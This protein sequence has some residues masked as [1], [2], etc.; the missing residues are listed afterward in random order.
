MTAA[1]AAAS[2]VVAAHTAAAA[3]GGA[4]P[5]AQQGTIT[6][7]EFADGASITTQYQPNG[8]VFGGDTPF[9]TDDGA[10]PTSPV[11]SGT[12]LFFGTITGTFVQPDGTAR[13]VDSFSL[14]VGY[15]DTPGSTE[16][17]AYDSGGTV[18]DTVPVS[19]FGIVHVT[20]SVPGIASFAV[21]SV[22]QGNPDP[23]GFAIDNLS[24]AGY[25]FLTGPPSPGEQGSAP[26][27]SENQT[28]CAKQEPVNCA[29]G[30]FFTQSADFTI[31][32]RGAPLS[33]SR[34][35]ESPLA[36]SDGPFGFGWANSYSMT[37]TTDGSG[38]ATISQEDGSTVTFIPNGSGGFTAPT[39]VLATLV[40][41]QDGTYT[42]TRDSTQIQYTFSA[43]GQLTRETDRNGY[44][45]GLTY[46]NGQLTSV[47]DPAGRKFTFSYSGGHVASVTDP[48]GRVWTY[49]YDGSGNLT[50]ATDPAGRTWS[51]T[52]DSNHLMLTVT[53]P[54]GGVTANVYN[55]SGQVVSQTDP[56]GGTTT[57]SYAGDPASPGGGTTTMTDP[58]NEV[59][60]YNYA[61]LELA[62][63]TNAAATADATTTSY[64]YD[65]AT[66][67]VTS[68]T[69]P[70]GNVSTSTYDSNG[71][72]LTST[73]PLGNTAFY[74]YNSFNE[75]LTKTT[76]LGETTSYTY[77]SSGNLLTSTDPLG[78]VTTYAYGDSTHPGDVTSVTDPGGNVAT[79]TYDAN[80]DLAS[81]TRSPSS[82]VTDTTAY[83]YDADGERTCTASPNAT[84][85]G[86][87]CPAAGG[88]VAADTTATTYNADG[89][90]TSVTD[91][92][93]RVTSY[94]YDA[95][96]NRSKVTDPAG[97][98]TSYGYNGNNWRTKV[99]RADGTSL[100]STYDA[101]GN[102][103]SQ[104]NGAGQATSYTYN[105][106][107]QVTSAT[108]PLGHKTTY[109]YDA[110]GNRISLTDPSGKVTSYSYDGDNRLTAISYSDG[111]TPGVS[112]FYDGDG[113]RSAM[114]DGTGTTSYTYDADGHLTS[115]QNGAGAAV[116][117]GYGPTGQVTSLTY[118]NGNTVSR[119]YNGAGEL[120]AISDWL[121][122]TTKF[123]YDHS[124]N[125]TSEAYPNG[126]TAAIGYDQANQPMS[127][128]DK[129]TSATVASFAY[130]RDSLG[131]VTSTTQGGSLSGSQNYSYTHL[132]QLA[133]DSTGSYSYDAA[134]NL[135]QM[136]GGVK[137]SY[138]AAGEV[139]S[140]SQPTGPQPPATD[141]VRSAN[142]TTKAAKIT[143]PAITTKAPGELILAFISAR[144]PATSK[145]KIA[146]V[147]GGGLTW[148][149]VARS[150]GERGTA[151]IWQA[152]A[153]ALLTSVKITASLLDKGYNGA[154]TVATFTGAAS[155]ASAHAT[156]GA[157]TGAPAVSLTTTGPDSLVWAAGEDSQHAK[158]RT[159]VSGQALVHQYLDTT[160]GGTSWTQK[161]IAAVP[162]AGATVKVADSAP[163]S[164]RWEF[165]A[166][167][168]PSAAAGTAQT[169]Y[170]YD[171]QGNRTSATLT[172]HPATSLGYDQA[173]RLTS[174]GTTASY[175]YDGDGLRMSKTIGTVTTAFSWDQSG[176]TPKLIEAGSTDYVYGPG[177]LPIE[178]ISGG[179]PTYLQT[180]QQGSVRLLTDA[181]GAVTGTYTYGPY[182]ITTGHTGTASTALRFD[183][184]YTD[185]ES[186]LQYLQNRYYDPV[187]AQ[188]LTVDPLLPA[189]GE[190]YGFAGGNPLNA[191]D[192]TGLS[193]Y[194]PFSWSGET[195]AA[196][197]I[198]VAVV[199]VTVLTLGAGDVVIGAGLTY[200]S[201]TTL[202][203]ETLA[204]TEVSAVSISA[205][206]TLDAAIGAAETAVTVGGLARSAVD[207][208][209]A[210]TSEGS[211][212]CAAEAGGLVLD[213]LTNSLIGQYVPEGVKREIANGAADA[214]SLGY[215]YFKKWLLRKVEGGPE[216]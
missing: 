183:G 143:S 160:T 50:S 168:I 66:L 40:Q 93:G 51:Y 57:W 9:I 100:S 10:N 199:G 145:Q 203:T 185:A 36:G 200:V 190:A 123:S 61:D 156:A 4:T 121:G 42:F 115:V 55:G 170:G 141:Q 175:A 43:S 113:H 146:G 34:T 92:D 24:F 151:E 22:D 205:E 41:N 13:T 148:S 64:T 7:S 65:P 117:Y 208:Y 173:N 14:D 71:N 108:D 198:G 38:D 84:A 165:A 150:N 91:P 27:E 15:I 48:L 75:V 69:D 130:T 54:R 25:S 157:G 159:A 16:V 161:V 60:V 79:F 147:T 181:T 172:G 214:L 184:Q 201:V 187:T 162:N 134:G 124:G 3:L 80:G 30:A 29:T 78:N 52:Y 5:P 104:V 53:D 18:L 209:N 128:T 196:V 11:L 32:G 39:R 63:V 17:I 191:T 127:I 182:G 136:P 1:Q 135:T 194:N 155:K 95:D 94:S 96:G 77:D 167:E 8:I 86:V 59:T 210:C 133:T 19:N 122:N 213:L 83:A 129:T 12:P 120:T 154:I 101:D 105:L 171:T 132:S 47:T 21:E 107:N 186:G 97:D 2:R 44:V 158:A 89:Q 131:Q 74:S 26:N 211:A 114:T 72:R 176:S 99:T 140:T 73:D 106:L 87:S 174:Y 177:G 109:A 178:Q 82:G 212:D 189:T 6:F 188:F 70:D 76:P 67:G 88:P 85:A 81:S 169:S 202:E 28:T 45:T 23:N 152:H 112:Y 98:V 206:F 116:S 163:T 207:T 62:S 46:T 216:C 49:Q 137:Q 126:V 192:P 195:W 68:V 215:D 111:T 142:E 180:D 56:A 197:G 179:T 138:N 166:V 20:V 119:T 153:A 90:I 35:Y 193:W 164:D 204:I 33:L 139:T 149:L 125:L 103:T 31:P 58:N 110:N 102:L 144:G 118:P 37:L